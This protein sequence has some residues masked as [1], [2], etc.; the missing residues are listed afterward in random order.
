[1]GAVVI[2]AIVFFVQ[3]AALAF[4]AGGGLLAVGAS[5]RNDA[6]SWTPGT[7][8]GGRTDTTHPRWMHLVS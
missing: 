4:L 6:P 1:M 5:R 2:D 7:D 8:R 3:V